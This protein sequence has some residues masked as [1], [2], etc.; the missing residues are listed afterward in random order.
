MEE[1]AG[2]E[3]RG[4]KRGEILQAK[5]IKSW[6][7]NERN[8]LGWKDWRFSNS[9]WKLEAWKHLLPGFVFLPLSCFLQNSGFDLWIQ[10]ELGFWWILLRICFYS[11][12]WITK[13]NSRIWC[14]SFGINSRTL[15]LINKISIVAFAFFL[16]L[17]LLSDWEI[18]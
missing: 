10:L 6:E 2:A 13:L 12:L 5:R 9:S 4:T 16:S 7:P 1:A 17:M 11:V 3:F 18:V 15:A 8:V 14:S